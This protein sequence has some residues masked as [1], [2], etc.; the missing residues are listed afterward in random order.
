MTVGWGNS[1]KWVY[2]S[3]IIQWLV[4]VCFHDGDKFQEWREGKPQCL[5][6]IEA[7]ACDTFATVSHWPVQVTWPSTRSV[8]DGIL[9]G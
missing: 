9:Q 4:Q 8:Q 6:T 3:L 1:S 2:G 7:S 5:I